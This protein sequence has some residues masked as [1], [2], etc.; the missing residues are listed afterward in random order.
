VIGI[1]EGGGS[2]RE[3]IPGMLELYRAGHF[4]FD[5][6]ITFYDFE[7]INQAVADCESGVAIKPVLRMR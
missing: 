2:A 5:R 7:N 1:I 4:A 3:M 6:L